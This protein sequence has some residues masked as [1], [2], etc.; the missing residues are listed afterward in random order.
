MIN[1]IKNNNEG[2]SIFSSNEEKI[3]KG[4]VLGFIKKKCINNLFSYE[5]YVKA[6]KKVLK[7]SSLVPVVISKSEVYFPISRVK[8]YEN[9]FI[10]YLAISSL[11]INKEQT[12]ITFFDG[13]TIKIDILK[14]K[15]ERIIN[16]IES[17]LKY[18]TFPESKCR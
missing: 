11:S 3:V 14:G 6:C 15:I 1:Y 18:K 10:N 16:N 5:G 7:I 17:I 4:T 8:D 9:I 2:I 13:Q 12:I